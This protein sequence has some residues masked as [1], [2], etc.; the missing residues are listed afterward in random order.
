MDIEKT[1][2]LDASPAKVWAVLLD[3]TA[4]G[5]CVPGMKSIDVLSAD[6]YVAVMQVK[7]SFITAKFKLHT[8]IV[9][10]REPSYLRAVGTGE[11]ASVASSLKQ[12][13]EMSLREL[14]D[15]RTEMRMKVTV[16]LV[17]RMG[18]FGLAV[19]KTKADRLWDEFGV[20]LAKR[21]SGDG[22]TDSLAQTSPLPDAAAPRVATPAVMAASSTAVASTFDVATPQPSRVGWFQQ[23]LNRFGS[24]Q[25]SRSDHIRVEIRKPDETLI[26]VSWPVAHSAEC[27]A[28]LRDV[29]EKR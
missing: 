26:T 14:E 6:E 13:T 16:D 21:V 25:S 7:I 3:P 24:P 8:R 29:I 2:L 19:M 18:S 22:V 17:G 5:A 28:W 11:D 10:K 12:T 1:L 15:G 9:E 23:V 4:M 20:N 27:S